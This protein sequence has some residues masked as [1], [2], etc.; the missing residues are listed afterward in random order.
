MTP[1]EVVYG[2]TALTLRTYDLVALV[3][4]T[5]VDLALM[6]RDTILKGLRAHLKLAH[7]RISKF[8]IVAIGRR[9]STSAVGCL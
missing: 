5:E 4:R 1:F 9:S 7:N 2:R 6:D 8:M 3:D